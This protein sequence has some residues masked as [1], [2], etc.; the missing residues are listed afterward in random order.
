MEKVGRVE[1]VKEGLTP[2]DQ[3]V[4]V[5]VVGLCAVALAHE[6]DVGDALALAGRVVVEVDLLERADGGGEELLFDSVS[7]LCE[8]R[9]A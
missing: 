5:L 1:R 6:G 8:P 7:L 4:V 9:S 3:P 2:V